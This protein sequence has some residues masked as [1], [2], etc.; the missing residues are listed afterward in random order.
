VTGRPDRRIRD[1]R[2]TTRTAV[3]PFG[4][5]GVSLKTVGEPQTDTPILGPEYADAFLMAADV[6]AHQLRKGSEVP[7]LAHLM[8]VSALVLDFGGDEECA[9]AALLHDTVE[10]CEDGWAMERRIRERFGDRVADIV[11]TCSDAIAVPGEPKTAW[12]PRKQQYIDDLETAT[13]DALL[14]SACD[15]LHNA[16]SVLGD[17]RIHG[18]AIWQR[19]STKSGPDQ[20]WYYT[21]LADLFSR[22]MPGPLADELHRV[23]DELVALEL[24]ARQHV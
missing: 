23:V 19:F 2:D 22:R 18:D 20:I 1:V 11:M 4:A 16:R 3:G 8:A 24:G 5:C 14:V 12:H 17:L 7:Y 15:K 6:H 21:T 9:M 10:D 13:D